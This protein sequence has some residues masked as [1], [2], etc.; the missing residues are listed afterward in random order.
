MIYFETPA[1]VYSPTLGLKVYSLTLPL[2]L[3]LVMKKIK[4]HS[5][6]DLF[7]LY[8]STFNVKIGFFCEKK[9]R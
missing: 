7:L 5:I 6:M 4:Y 2:L 1:C 3:F 9:I 8:F